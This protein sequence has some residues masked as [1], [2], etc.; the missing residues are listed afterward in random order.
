[1]LDSVADEPTSDGSADICSNGTIYWDPSVTYTSTCPMNMQRFPFDEQ[2]CTFTF[3]SWVYVDDELT[4]TFYDSVP[5]VDRTSYVPSADWELLSTGANRHFRCDDVS[6][7]HYDLTFYIV[8][9]RRPGFY[10]YVLIVPSLLLSILTP[11][12]FCIPPSRP[13]RTNLGRYRFQQLTSISIRRSDARFV[14]RT[15]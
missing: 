8:I 9:R 11:A 7:K 2:N 12:I 15:V 5:N 4:L 3:S 10:T 1:L 6:F 13:D 14:T